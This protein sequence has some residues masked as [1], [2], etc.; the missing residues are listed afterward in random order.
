MS[1]KC[2]D[3]GGICAEENLEEGKYGIICPLCGFEVDIENKEPEETAH[4]I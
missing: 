3:C 1:W 2:P 4:D